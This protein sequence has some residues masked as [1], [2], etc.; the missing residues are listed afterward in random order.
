MCSSFFFGFASNPGIGATRLR[1]AQAYHSYVGQAGEITLGGIKETG[2][3]GRQ[4]YREVKLEISASHDYNTAG[5]FFAR[6]VLSII[7][8]VHVNPSRPPP[9]YLH[10]LRTKNRDMHKGKELRAERWMGKRG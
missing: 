5:N 10:T 4:I 1:R 6:L 2:K 9:R 8:S 7:K 3:S